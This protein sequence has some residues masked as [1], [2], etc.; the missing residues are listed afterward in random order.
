VLERL[1]GPRSEEEL[2]QRAEEERARHAER[3]RAW[4]R[5]YWRRTAIVIGASGL[6]VLGLTHLEP[7]DWRDAWL[8]PALFAA[9]TFV[10]I[11]RG[12][13]WLLGLPLLALAPVVVVLL[14]GGTLPY[15]FV[16]API[17]GAIAL[18]TAYATPWPSIGE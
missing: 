8:L 15:W 18:A 13:L 10:M 5:R 3:D 12:W 9:L 2:A 7:A 1:R 14:C 11:W 17:L 6:A 16:K 4:K